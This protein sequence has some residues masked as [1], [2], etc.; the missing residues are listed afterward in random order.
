[1][2]KIDVKLSDSGENAGIFHDLRYTNDNYGGNQNSMTFE[3]ENMSGNGI[4]IEGCFLRQDKHGIWERK[5]YNL[6][7]GNDFDGVRINITG[8]IEN[9]EFLQMLQL[10]LQAE[11]MVEI[12]KP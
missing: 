12:I 9:S 1:M 8:S 3:V 5:W 11:K 2:S 7:N 4:T 6:G 10:I